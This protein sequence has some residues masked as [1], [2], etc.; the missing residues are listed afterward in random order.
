ML[1]PALSRNVKPG[2]MCLETADSND[3]PCESRPMR[4]EAIVELLE[5]WTKLNGVRETVRN[6]LC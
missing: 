6:S 1:E 2:R 3:E 5:R 4:P